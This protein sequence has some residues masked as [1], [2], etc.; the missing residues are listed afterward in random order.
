MCLKPGNNL[1]CRNS[2]QETIGNGDPL[3]CGTCCGIG[4]GGE[5]DIALLQVT[6]ADGD[7][8]VFRTGSFIRVL[9]SVEIAS[10]HEVVSN[11]QKFFFGTSGDVSLLTDETTLAWAEEAPIAK[12]DE[13][14]FRTGCFVDFESEAACFL[15]VA[16]PED[17]EFVFRTGC[18]V[19]FEKAVG[20]L[21]HQVAVYL[22]DELI[23][24]SGAQL[25]RCVKRLQHASKSLTRGIGG[26]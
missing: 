22:S 8:F 23:F 12:G 6:I 18:L 10:F 3:G 26:K 24:L 17:D 13:F 4:F 1:P 25:D 14:V 21:F 11:C 9:G 2:L 16:I 20:A 19:D 7:E 5:M 15:E